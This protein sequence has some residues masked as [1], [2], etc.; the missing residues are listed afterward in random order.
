ME[1]HKFGV[2]YPGTLFMETALG[3]PARENSAWAF[4]A[5][6]HWNEIRDSGIQPDARTQVQRNVSQRAFCRI[7][8]GLTRAWKIVCRCL[9]A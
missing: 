4:H 9:T 1:K 7:R 5:P 3:P 8:T 6:M 2:T